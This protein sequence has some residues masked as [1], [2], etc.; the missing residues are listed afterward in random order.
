MI[1]NLVFIMMKF[2]EIIIIGISTIIFLI[3]IFLYGTSNKTMKIGILYA[4]INC[5]S[6]YKTEIFPIILLITILYLI[7]VSKILLKK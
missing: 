6:L 3:V 7:G 2:N 1:L 4:M 5:I